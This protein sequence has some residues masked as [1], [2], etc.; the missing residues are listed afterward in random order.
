MLR[1]NQGPKGCPR[2]KAEGPCCRGVH[3]NLVS[4]GA[5]PWDRAPQGPTSQPGLHALPGSPA[6]PDTQ[7]GEGGWFPCCGP[8]PPTGPGPLPVRPLLPRRRCICLAWGMGM[9]STHRLA[10]DCVLWHG[11]GQRASTPQSRDGQPCQTGTLQGPRQYLGW[12][13]GQEAAPWAVLG[14]WEHSRQDKYMHVAG[15]T[16]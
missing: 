12:L 14:T 7:V 2:R 11:T 10:T 13:R 15:R 8:S 16:I 6:G 9:K 5:S 3:E 4:P 1:K